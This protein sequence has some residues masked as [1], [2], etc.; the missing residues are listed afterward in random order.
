MA[1]VKDK[2]RAMMSG[3]DVA[4]GPCCLYRH[5]GGEIVHSNAQTLGD[6]FGHGGSGAREVEIGL[7][8]SRLEAAP[9]KISCEGPVSA[10]VLDNKGAAVEVMPNVA[11]ADVA[12]PRHRAFVSYRRY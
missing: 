7:D 6:I 2:I 8:C 4:E 12:L 3:D 5:G 11:P 9:V 10:T 1:E